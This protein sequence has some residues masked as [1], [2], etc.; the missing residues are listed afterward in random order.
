MV[1]QGRVFLTVAVVGALV[2][3]LMVLIL[4]N[5]D[6]GTG[7]HMWFRG[8]EPPACT[9]RMV[10]ERLTGRLCPGSGQ[11]RPGRPGRWRKSP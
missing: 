11:N 7:V 2:L 3:G 8:T 6:P 4:V 1:S 10:Q 9:G 5:V